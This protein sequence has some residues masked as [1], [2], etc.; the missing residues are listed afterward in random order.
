MRKEQID[1]KMSATRV[2]SAARGVG[3]IRL[4]RRVI[5]GQGR[6]VDTLG[7]IAGWMGGGVPSGI[8]RPGLVY[9]VA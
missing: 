5:P 8:R 9:G 6:V 4:D 1:S 2:E 7:K 3:S